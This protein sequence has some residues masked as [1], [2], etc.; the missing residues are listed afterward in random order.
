[1]K[2][3]HVI[4]TFDL[5]AGG[6]PRIALRLAAATAA[7]GHE[8]TLASF[9]P[10]PDIRAAFAAD[11]A[12]VPG[13]SRVTLL[14]LP[15]LSGTLDRLTGRS[16][17]RALRQAV[18]TF[19][20]VHVHDV[21]TA[22]SRAAM[23]AA[24]TAGVPFVL[25]PNGMLDPWSLAQKRL[26]KSLVLAAGH[27]RLINRAAF[28]HVGNVD[29]EQGVRLAG[30]T[31]PTVIV[32]NGINSS[33]F[34][35]APLPG[36]F[37]ADHPELAGRPYLLFLGR[38]HFK[39]GLDYL[40]TAF[41]TV[42]TRHPEVQLV[43]AGPDDGAGEPFRAAIAAAGLAS[44]VHMPGAILGTDRYAVLS[45]ATVF[46]LPSR[47]EGFSIAVLEA[48]ASGVPVV[49]SDACH[50][51]EVATSGAGRV[52]PLDAG[53]FAEAIDGVLSD[54]HRAAMGDAGRALVL[55]QYTWS[56]VAE[57]LVS[58]YVRFVPPRLMS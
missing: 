31:V 47:Q 55:S 43:V 39:K 20:V 12:S 21:W 58:A 51:P 4:P 57:R 22:I 49:I 34:S 38:L 28:L 42:A 35:P 6:P 30:I 8:T 10:P 29:E 2:I 32:P 9:A 27:R 53:Q 52:V 45:G 56:A 37:H 17:V 40:A 48:L 33:E 50:F 46:V 13:G 16:A 54:T 3:L 23:T 11:Q 24:T 14:E 1:M 19:D 44:R 41:A 7:L 5:A 25:L 15:P 26:K 18:G 36:A